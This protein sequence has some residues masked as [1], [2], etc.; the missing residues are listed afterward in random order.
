MT[1]D[2]G[3]GEF[4]MRFITIALGL[5]FGGAAATSL[6]AH[7]P[8]LTLR[9]S[10]LAAALPDAA[11]TLVLFGGLGLVAGARRARSNEVAD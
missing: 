11:T 4:F 1:A 7:V 9:L 3:T 6:A 5:V 2:G 10:E 8:G